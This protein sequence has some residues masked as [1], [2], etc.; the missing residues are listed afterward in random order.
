MEAT[1]SWFLVGF[2]SAAPPRELP[3]WLFIHKTQKFMKELLLK[4]KLVLRGKSHLA[5]RERKPCIVLKYIYVCVYICIS[6]N[7]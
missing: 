6:H 5:L 7:I 2:V 3:F 1:T 4:C